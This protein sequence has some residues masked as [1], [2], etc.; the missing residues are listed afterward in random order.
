MTEAA[1]GGIEEVETVQGKVKLK[2]PQGTQPNT[3]IRIKGKGV[4]H[5]NS[6]TYGDHYVRVQVEVPNKL[7]TRQKELLEELQGE[8]KKKRW[9]GGK[10]IREN[11]LETVQHPQ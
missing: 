8:G 1:L 7:S 5:V 2:I 3:L 11:I 10:I 4:K 6:S 9:F